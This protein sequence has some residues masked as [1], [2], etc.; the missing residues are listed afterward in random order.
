MSE[1]VLPILKPSSIGNLET[2]TA[3]QRR[4][5]KGSVIK[6]R[7]LHYGSPTVGQHAMKLVETL[8]V[9][10]G[11]QSFCAVEVTSRQLKTGVGMDAEAASR[12]PVSC[13]AVLS[14]RLHLLRLMSSPGKCNLGL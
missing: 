7:H 2:R 11:T 1:G 14:I 10:D 13:P 5:P 9:C 4:A 8:W 3:V 12:R 6:N